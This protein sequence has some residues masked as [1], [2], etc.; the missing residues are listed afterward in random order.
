[1]A[2]WPNFRSPLMW[3]VFAVNTYLSVS[4]IFWFIGLIPDFATLRDKSTKPLPKVIY[5][6]L[7]MGWRGSNQHWHRYEQAYLLLA[8][9]STPLVLSVHSI[10]SFD[11]AVSIVPGWAVTVFPPYF[12]A[13]A[14]FAG[15]AM[16]I[17]F[18][19][20]LR[21]WYPGF[22]DLIT[23]RHLDWMAKVLLATGLI[24]FYGYILEFFYALYSGNPY[25]L[26]LKNFRLESVYNWAYFALIICNGLIP[27]IFWF[28]AA[29][30]NTFWLVFVCLS[31]T[32]GMWLERFVI[33]PMSLMSNYVPSSN[34]PYYPTIWD[35]MMFAGT[36]GLFLTLMF[37][38]F[39]ALPVV[40]MFEMK[41]LLYRLAKAGQ[42]PDPSDPVTKREKAIAGGG[43]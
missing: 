23:V 24:V 39:R 32:V 25:E 8:G 5:G 13:G 21:K 4:A 6:I 3:D 38:F 9:L 18:A 42:V 43:E 28:P 34:Q 29:R 1:M 36:V 37:L 19:I 11:F 33:I 15:F 2:V 27:Q 14:V 26:A 7:S 12:V 17:L 35:F 40:N 22:K 10:V 31:V 30:R 20:P 16:V 41:D